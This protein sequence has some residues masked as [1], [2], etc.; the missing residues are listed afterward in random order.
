MTCVAHINFLMT[1]LSPCIYYY[2]PPLIHPDNYSHQTSLF[3]PAGFFILPVTQSET[4][5]SFLTY[6]LPSPPLLHQDYCIVSEAFDGAP[7]FDIPPTLIQ[8]PGISRTCDYKWPPSWSP[9]FL[10]PLT[11]PGR[12]IF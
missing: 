3:L 4:P 7:L 8:V 12:A 5:L 6:C 2:F 1:A 10:I 9:C 11:S